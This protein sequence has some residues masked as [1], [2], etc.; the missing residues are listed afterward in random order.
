M[1]ALGAAGNAQLVVDMSAVEF[2]DSTGMNVLLTA[3]RLAAERGS[4]LLL[5]APRAPVRK[6]LEVT[7]L[8]SVFTVLDDLA[9][10]SGQ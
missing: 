5:A 1:R 6:I 10:P 7:G 2:C 8:Q 4:D 3:H 9:A